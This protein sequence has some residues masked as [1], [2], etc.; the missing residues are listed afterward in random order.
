M[1]PINHAVNSAIRYSRKFY[2]LP[3]RVSAVIHFVKYR[4]Q[5]MVRAA[6]AFRF[7][8]IVSSF[9]FKYRLSKRMLRPGCALRLIETSKSRDIRPTI[10]LLD[11]RIS[12]RN[13]IIPEGENRKARFQRRNSASFLAN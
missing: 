7:P 10:A 4:Y 11:R 2:T 12:S 3:C 13:E 1:L 8:Q 5:C 9:A 6:T